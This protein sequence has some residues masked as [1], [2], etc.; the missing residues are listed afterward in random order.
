MIDFSRTASGARADLCRLEGAGEVG[1]P[2]RRRKA[3]QSPPAIPGVAPGATAPKW[4]AT[5]CR[6]R[7]RREEA[8][9]QEGEEAVYPVESN[10]LY[11]VA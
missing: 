10:L 2:R 3:L 8:A 7:R 9:N 11:K 4:A 5:R 6:R 1:E